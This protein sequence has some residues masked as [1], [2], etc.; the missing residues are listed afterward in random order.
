MILEVVESEIDD[1]SFLQE[2]VEQ[3]EQVEALVDDM[4]SF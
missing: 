4:T 3:E 2:Y 1:R